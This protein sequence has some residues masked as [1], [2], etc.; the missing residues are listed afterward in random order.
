MEAS[1]FSREMERPAVQGPHVTVASRG[2]VPPTVLQAFH[3]LPRPQIWQW[4]WGPGLR[5]GAGGSERGGG[6]GLW[7]FIV[8]QNEGG[9]ERTG[10]PPFCARTKRL[11]RG[12]GAERKALLGRG[13]RLERTGEGTSFRRS[14]GRTWAGEENETG[15]LGLGCFVNPERQ[16]VG[17]WGAPDSA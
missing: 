1:S 2:L 15:R 9:T 17:Q 14:C 4:F 8:W 3:A 10:E 12:R 16:L 13:S 11:V 6:H 7:E 5:T